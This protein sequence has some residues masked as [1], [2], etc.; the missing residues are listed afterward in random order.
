MIQ[1]V[2]GVLICRHSR[3][4]R[5]T[6]PSITGAVT[7]LGGSG[8]DRID[9]GG[10]NVSVLAG[11]GND[12]IDNHGG[13][14]TTINTGNGLNTV[15]NWFSDSVTIGGGKDN[16]QLESHGGTNISIKAGAG[17]DT[18]FNYG[19]S[20]T[21]DAGDGNDSIQHGSSNSTILCDNGN[22]TVNILSYWSGSEVMISLT[23]GTVVATSISDAGGYY[24]ERR[25]RLYY[26]HQQSSSQ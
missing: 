7:V 25:E 9:N 24:S 19:D 15:Y 6:T 4:A 3:A 2:V 16:D 14:N 22:D 1:P 12:V 21:V 8:D 5:A 23:S 26:I 20:V 17:D 13:N 10:N 18:I 11:Y